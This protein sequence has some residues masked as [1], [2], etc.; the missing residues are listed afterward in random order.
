MQVLGVGGGIIGELHLHSHHVGVWAERLSA[1]AVLHRQAL[2]GDPVQQ[3]IVLQGARGRDRLQG[4][5]DMSNHQVQG[6]M[7]SPRVQAGECVSHISKVIILCL[8]L[9]IVAL[10]IVK[11]FQ[12]LF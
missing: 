4:E 8:T 11:V 2:P 12:S 1:E 3:L 5:G 9:W 6:C 10:F 7:F